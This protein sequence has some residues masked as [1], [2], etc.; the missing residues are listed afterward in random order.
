MYDASKSTSKLTKKLRAMTKPPSISTVDS[1]SSLDTPTLQGS[2]PATPTTSITTTPTYIEASNKSA[3][4]K[5]TTRNPLRLKSKLSIGEVSPRNVAMTSRMSFD[6]HSEG[7]TT[8]SS[9]STFGH[10]DAALM[11]KIEGGRDRANSTIHASASMEDFTSLGFSLNCGLDNDMPIAE[12]P[13]DL[14]PSGREQSHTHS[15]NGVMMDSFL[16]ARTLSTDNYLF[17]Q[18]FIPTH[19]DDDFGATAF[20]PFDDI[21]SP[22]LDPHHP[23]TAPMKASFSELQSRS[24]LDRLDISPSRDGSAKNRGP[25]KPT[26]TAGEKR[27]SD[28]GMMISIPML[29]MCIN[30]MSV[31]STGLSGEAI[32]YADD[33]YRMSSKRRRRLSQ[34]VPYPRKPRQADYNCGVCN[35]TY[36]HSVDDN[37]W[38]AIYQHECP[39]CNVMQIPRL[40][41]SLE[42]NAIELDPNVTALYGEGM[43][44]GDVEGYDT[45]GVYDSDEGIEGD[46]ED[47]MP[48]GEVEGCGGGVQYDTEMTEHS[49]LEVKKEAYPFDQE[50]LLE[51]QQASKLLVLMTHARTCTGVHSSTKHAE[52]C[53]STKY[54]MLHIRDCTGFEAGT[55]KQC[56]FQWCTPC[57]KM[58]KHLTRCYEPTKCNVCNPCS[59][60]ESFNQLRNI[61]TIRTPPALCVDIAQGDRL[62]YASKLEMRD[63]MAYKIE[64]KKRTT[65]ITLPS[66]TAYTSGGVSGVSASTNITL[67]QHQLQQ[68]QQQV[69]MPQA[70]SPFPPLSYH[71]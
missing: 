19:H 28:D 55:G 14:L 2:Q 37:P 26:T 41:I 64:Q 13:T 23:T 30:G 38:W 18:D 10:N 71:L 32:N 54:L 11:V 8:C 66:S 47:V 35:E 48:G 70:S 34:I 69:A 49:E 33:D 57:K 9:E 42:S 16:G 17:G 1:V 45:Y 68:Q 12:E 36:T 7:Y 4:A 65:E 52:I 56:R 59:L 46:E 63:D 61:N 62:T 6:T 27:K 39:K 60:P 58:L 43:D 67:Q 51:Q 29:P 31:S 44:D 5:K 25:T 20:G 53:N 24:T 3:K 50:G 21:V 40:D 15:G 22:G